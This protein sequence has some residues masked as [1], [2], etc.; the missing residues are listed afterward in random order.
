MKLKRLVIL[1]SLIAWAVIQVSCTATKSARTE[2]AAAGPAAQQKNTGTKDPQKLEAEEKL[3]EAKKMEILGD[4]Q[5]AINLYKECLKIDPANDAAFYEAAKIFFDQKEYADALAY[6]SQAVKIN[7]S[8]EWYLDL[9]GTL[10]GGSGNYKEAIHVYEQMVQ[11]NP[12]NTEAWFNW[13][14]FLDQNRQTVDAINV[15]NQIEERFGLNEDIT[16]EKVKLWMKLGKPEKAAAELQKL[17][18]PTRMKHDII[19]FSWI[20][21][22]Q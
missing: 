7:P 18:M 1:S 17:M 9:Y 19:P 15:F 16:A 22:G 11:K 20:L 3:I 5:Q 14:F 8:N 6:I 21:Y 10:L 2:G 12:D 4:N 13:A